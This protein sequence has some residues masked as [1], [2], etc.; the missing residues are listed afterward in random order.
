M[1]ADPRARS[2]RQLLD[3]YRIRLFAQHIRTTV[4]VSAQRIER[5]V[6]GLG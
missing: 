5:F 6:A 4:P 3:E 1:L 2:G